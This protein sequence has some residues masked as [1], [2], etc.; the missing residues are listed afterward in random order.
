MC[1]SETVLQLAFESE[2][3]GFV[4]L[5]STREQSPFPVSGPGVQWGRE[6]LGQVPV[7]QPTYRGVLALP[8][9]AGGATGSRSRP[10][11]WMPS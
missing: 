3:V 8:H 7:A 11:G 6:K 9:G 10:T 4:P 2:C 5:P 1:H